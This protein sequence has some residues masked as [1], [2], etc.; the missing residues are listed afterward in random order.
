MSLYR[1]GWANK[2]NVMNYYI[3]EGFFMPRSFTPW[4]I[5]AYKEIYKHT[6]FKYYYY[7]IPKSNDIDDRVNTIMS[8]E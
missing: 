4:N 3:D 6:G 1:F 5:L 2:N 7:S 8:N